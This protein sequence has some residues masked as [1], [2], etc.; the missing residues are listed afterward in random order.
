MTRLVRY[1][2][3]LGVREFGTWNEVNHKTQPTWDSP[4][5]SAQYFKDMYRIVKGRCRSCIVVALD[6]LDQRGVERY[7]R[8][9]Y[10][11]L[12]PTWRKR[13]SVVGIHNYSD[14]NRSRSRG[15]SAII[16]TVRRFN[17]RTKIW[18]TET[19]A[20]AAFGS[21]FKFNERRQASRMRN[22]F[23]YA[24]RFRRSGV[25]RV[26]SY[27]WFGVDQPNC[28]ERCGFDAGLVRADGSTRPA[29]DTF[30]ARVRS[31]SR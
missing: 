7:I 2:R 13:A 11:R 21:S 31:Y 8:S 14:V 26:Y 24:S 4:G 9:F 10:S 15:T 3:T 27:N 19:G 6:V 22:M 17:R 1:F 28:G 23:T 25:D 20:L 12:S 30:R 18:F 5:H 29:Y 16:R